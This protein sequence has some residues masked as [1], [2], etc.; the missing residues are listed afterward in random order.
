MKKH[1]LL[2]LLLFGVSSWAIGQEK[3]ITGKVTSDR[4]G[5]GIPGVTI[6]VENS[7]KATLSAADGSFAINAS[8]GDVLTFS[9]IGFSNTS[10]TIGAAT[11]L[12]IRMEQT[13]SELDEV[14][15]VAYGTAKRSSLTGSVS[16]ISPKSFNDVPEPSIE[17]SLVGKVAGVSINTTSGQTGATSTIRIRGIG[18]MNASNEPLF[19][20]DGVPVVNGDLGQASGVLYSSNNIMATINPNDIESISILKDAAASSLYGSRA[21]NGVILIN[22][23]KG[24]SGQA[25][26]D[27]RTSIGFTPD[28]ATENYRPGDPQE[29]IQYFY[30]IF[31][32]Y[33]TSNGY[34]D[35]Q[36]NKYALDRMTSRFGMHGYEFSSDG[37]GR[38]ANIT[39][40]GK[41]DGVENRDGKYFDWNDALFRT[42]VYQTNDLSFSS[43]T[44]KSTIY[45]SVSFTTD[46]G[47]AYTDALSRISGRMNITQKIAKF[48][49]F[50][51]SS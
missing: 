9:A 39:I 41:T 49:E 17:K 7:T 6:K 38:Y 36:A 51:L 27:F 42:G 37:T 15:V 19:V 4:D 28:W 23:K 32:D 44:D 40:K 11:V 48:I 24:R 8:S 46:K 29:Q 1:L 25:K 12:N 2:I 45:S 14:V 26:I 47:R 34:T 31:H 33:R 18:S 35:E 43:G 5:D 10:V 50:F 20:I 30:W 22:T 16:T 13:Q 21:A 3:R